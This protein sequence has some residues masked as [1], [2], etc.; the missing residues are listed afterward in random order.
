MAVTYSAGIQ[1]GCDCAL[2]SCCP[3]KLR[4][5]CAL[6]AGDGQLHRMHWQTEAEQIPFCTNPHTKGERLTDSNSASHKKT[7]T[8][9]S[10][11]LQNDQ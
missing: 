3:G 7:S 4:T 8:Y 9:K 11:L 5:H 1:K 6:A 2:P 10:L